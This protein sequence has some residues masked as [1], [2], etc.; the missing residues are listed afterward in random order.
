MG[1]LY[2]LGA[3]LLTVYGQVI[4]WQIS[5]AG[6]FPEGI[7]EKIGFL[8]CMVLNPWVISSLCCAFLAF[9]CWMAAMTKFDLSYA[10][11]FMSLSFVMV[12]VLSALFFQ[13]TITLPK[14]CGVSFI[15]L[16]IAI[17]AQG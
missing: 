6:A 10:Y 4:K 17:G 8:L 3:V 14:V 5:K 11:P 1:Y 7:V 15:M 13:E 16:G 12:L 9:L 2:I